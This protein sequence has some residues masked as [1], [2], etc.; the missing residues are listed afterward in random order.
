MRL[1]T[2]EPTGFALSAGDHIARADATS[3]TSMRCS[4][5]DW[6][7]W[8]SLFEGGCAMLLSGRQ[9][10]GWRL[11]NAAAAGRIAERTMLRVRDGTFLVLRQTNPRHRNGSE[12]RSTSIDTETAQKFFCDFPFKIN[13][14]RF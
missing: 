8:A 1:P 14:A 11:G 6:P 9:M 13:T 2:V 10:E 7:F 3:L 5:T 12:R 4:A